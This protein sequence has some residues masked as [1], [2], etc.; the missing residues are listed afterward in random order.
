VTSIVSGRG[1]VLSAPFVLAAGEQHPD[2]PKL[3]DPFLRFASGQT[4]G[5]AALAEMHLQP[6]SPGPNLHVHTREDELFFVLDS[7]MTVQIAHELYEVSAG[8]MAWGPRGIAHAYANRG[9]EPLHL[10]IMWIPGGAEGLFIEMG[11]HLRSTHGVADPQ[12]G[13]HTSSLR[14]QTRRTPDRGSRSL[15]SRHR[16]PGALLTA[17]ERRHAMA[18][19]ETTPPK[20]PVG[21]ERDRRVPV[22]PVGADVPWVVTGRSEQNKAVVRHFVIEASRGEHRSAGRNEHR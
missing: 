7:V 13:Q 4:D 20:L 19:N 14:R 8:G 17:S 22:K 11:D 18:A 9:R 10:L 16:Y 5:L 1:G 12:I 21:A 3:T 6:L 15:A 2:A